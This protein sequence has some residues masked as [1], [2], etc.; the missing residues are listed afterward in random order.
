LLLGFFF[1]SVGMQAQL[2]LVWLEP[3]LILSGVAAVIL[4][5]MG[6][7]LLLGRIAGQNWANAVRFAVA[8]PQGSEF[9]FV[10][11]A[12]AVGVGALTPAMAGR[13]TLVIALS[14]AATPLLFAASE[15]FVIP[16]LQPR[17]TET[18]DTIEDQ[19]P[20]IVCG[21]GRMGQ[22]VCRV[23]RMQGI[24]FIALEQDAAQ[25]EV[26]R[27]FGATVYF[28]S[29]TR[30]DL[31]RS[32]GAETA[33]LLIVALDDMEESLQVVDI[34][35]RTFP[36]LRILARARNRRHAHL[37]MD[38]GIA[39]IVRET[40]F[41]SLRLTELTLMELGIPEAEARRSVALFRDFDEKALV[42]SHAYYED[43]RRVI[44][45]AQDQAAELTGLFEADQRRT[46]R[47]AE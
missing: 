22:I 8:L 21:V 33:K 24:P 7:A 23:L 46:R 37:L 17:K 34:A 11:F 15:R 14:M 1:M 41:S 4:A 3:G 10:L 6:V 47:A 28:G 9:S 31:L 44:Q 38:R 43:E 16:R 19:A 2:S 29:P 5:N 12:A 40:F 39:G 18:Y 30:P 26:L 45:N 35:R 20:V 25:V 27:R 32:A 36:K 13:A 42:E